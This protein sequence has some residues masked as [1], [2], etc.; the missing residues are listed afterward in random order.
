MLHPSFCSYLYNRKLDDFKTCEYLSSSAESFIRR[1]ITTAHNWRKTG[2]LLPSCL[3]RN[4]PTY[5]CSG[6]FQQNVSKNN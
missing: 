1:G 2:S 4:S 5:E 3:P 6:F